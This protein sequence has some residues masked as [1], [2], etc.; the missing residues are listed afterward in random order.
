MVDL[1][2]RDGLCLPVDLLRHPWTVGEGDPAKFDQ[3]IS[4]MDER[5]AHDECV[6][7]K[8][9]AMVQHERAAPA[10]GAIDVDIGLEGDMGDDDGLALDSDFGLDGLA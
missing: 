8:L 3:L 1:T 9:D 2:K 6:A 7:Q 5:L 4:Q 10:V